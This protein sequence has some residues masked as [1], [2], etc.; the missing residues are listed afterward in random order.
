M[1]DAFTTLGRRDAVKSSFLS[2][3]VSADRLSADERPVYRKSLRSQSK[4]VVQDGKKYIDTLN[5]CVEA[6]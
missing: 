2:K 6:L 1:T 5:V 3:I 4:I